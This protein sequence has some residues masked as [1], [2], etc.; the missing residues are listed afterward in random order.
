M[1]STDRNAVEE[2]LARAL[3]DPSDGTRPTQF[4][5]EG[6]ELVFQGGGRYPCHEGSP[7]LIAEG[8]SLFRVSDVLSKVP[9]TQL[10]SYRDRG[11]LKNHVRQRIFPSLTRDPG[12]ARRMAR[13]ADEVANGPVLILGAGAKGESSRRDFPN[14][15]VVTTDV[16]LQFGIDLVCDAHD[17]PFADGTFGLVF[18]DQVLEHVARPWRVAAEMERVARPGGLVYAATPFV[19]PHHGNGYDFQRFTSTGLRFLFPRSSSVFLT[20]AGGPYSAS[21]TILSQALI[22]LSRR[23]TIRRAA[24]AVARLTLWPLK[25]LD[26][27]T[28]SQPDLQVTAAKGLAFLGRVDGRTR[29]DLELFNDARVSR[30][31]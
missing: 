8:S 30:L 5:P 25:H 20:S 23:R 1:S 29:S 19:F 21:A 16:H 17:I 9:T 12:Y 10:A 22:D 28:D 27:L 7:V 11:S 26:R 14:S 3:I 13:L 2:L 24:L 6:E 15:V 18:A 31:D 4:P